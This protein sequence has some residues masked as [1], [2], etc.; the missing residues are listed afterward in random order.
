MCTAVLLYPPLRRHS[1]NPPL[2]INKHNN[3]GNT[4]KFRLTLHKNYGKISLKYSL[5][6]YGEVRLMQRL[7]QLKNKKGFTLVE[8]IV[9]LAMIGVLTAIILPL[10]MNAGKPQA[11]VA[12]AK[13]FYF[14]S[15][16]ILIQ[17][18]ADSPELQTGYLSY[19]KGAMTYTINTGDYLYICA[20]AE[21]N[22]GFTELKLAKLSAPADGTA[23]NPATGYTQFQFAAEITASSTDHSLLDKLNTFSTDD[24]E[25]YYYALVDDQC[26]VIMT[27]WCE[28]FIDDISKSTDTASTYSKTTIF[29]TDNYYVDGYLLGAYPERYSML[30]YTMFS[31]VDLP[32]DPSTSTT[33]SATPAPAGP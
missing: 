11:A 6:L 4:S 30:G 7:M 16:R 13:S 22:N 10:S 25:G 20:K 24:D 5:Q 2:F 1:N 27:Y 19:K 15:Q 14:G 12:K 33:A 31:E 21:K 3:T 18:R 17:Y 9:V 8:L 23:A 26:K 29:P 28:T 32:A